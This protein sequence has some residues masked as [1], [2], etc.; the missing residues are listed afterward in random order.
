MYYGQVLVL[1]Q[2]YCTAVSIGTQPTFKKGDII[3]EAHII[4]F[5]G[6]LYGQ[7]LVINLHRFIRDQ[8][9]FGSND[10]LIQQI[11]DDIEGINDL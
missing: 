9:S 11:E 6:D 10:E 1:G 7:E 4:G 8:Q 3:I 2:W 5:K